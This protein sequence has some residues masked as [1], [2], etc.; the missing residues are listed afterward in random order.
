[1]PRCRRRG[2]DDDSDDAAPHAPLRDGCGR[3]RPAPR[4][5]ARRLGRRRRRAGRA[6]GQRAL[7]ADRRG[8]ARHRRLLPRACRA[9]QAAGRRAPP[10][11]RRGRGRLAR[12]VPRQPLRP[13]HRRRHERCCR[14][15]RLRA[16]SDLDVAQHRRR[17]VRRLAARPQRDAAAGGARRLLWPRPVQHVHLDRGGARAP[18]SRRPSGG[19]ARARPLRVLRTLRRRQPGVRLCD[20]LRPRRELRAG[21]RRAA[22]RARRQG[23]ARSRAASPTATPTRTSTPSRTP[24][25]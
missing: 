4:G 10:R 3:C 12:R 24:A 7:R 19:A 15:R 13:R 2:H 25:S 21:G 11:R 14:A 8:V 22:A 9:D 1:M 23:V 20:A 16:L 6:A 17:R 5:A 18:R